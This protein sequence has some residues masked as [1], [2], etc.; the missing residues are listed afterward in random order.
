L[1][2]IKDQ[3]AVQ[4]KMTP[5]PTPEFVQPAPYGVEL[6]AGKDYW[7]CSCGK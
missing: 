3:N 2:K 6:E 7:F 4:I 5:Q 1:K